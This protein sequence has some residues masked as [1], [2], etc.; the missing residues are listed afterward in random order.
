V[1]KYAIILIFT[2]VIALFTYNAT[3]SD[4]SR[5]TLTRN[6]ESYNNNQ[7]RNIANSAIQTLL[8]KIVDPDDNEFDVS[9]NNVQYF[10]GDGYYYWEELNGNYRYHIENQ[11]DTLLIVTSTGVVEGGEYSVDVV[12]DIGGDKWE[13]QF[14]LAVFAEKSIEMHASSRVIGHVGTNSTE[15]NAVK[16]T[17]VATIDSSLYIGP[18][19]DPD[20][21]VDI[22]AWRPTEQAI[23]GGIKNLNQPHNY[24]MPEFPDFPDLGDSQGDII[25]SGGPMNNLVLQPSDFHNQYFDEVKIQNNRTLTLNLGDQ[26]W[27]IR[28]GILN[29]HQGHLILN[30]TGA[31]TFYIEDEF[32][33]GGSST[34]NQNGQNS[35]S[36]IYYQGTD[37]I[38]IAGATKFKSNLFIENADLT[39]T[40]AGA[41]PL[42]TGHIISG[43]QNVTIAGAGSV[44]SGVIYAPTSHVIMGGSGSATTTI[45]SDTFESSGNARVYH[46][47]SIGD[48]FPDIDVG[49]L[50]YVIK[51]WN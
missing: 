37:G 24:P 1:G 47:G 11:D 3:M 33:I 22:P 18:G 39:I 42:E 17:G 14:P 48:D 32:K 44:Q 25:V 49:G 38:S 6:I 26:D 51:S 4:L 43:G 30:G 29:I 7:A 50:E 41:V 10:P 12:L 31:I 23:K 35:Q 45:V 15:T 36:M 9:S 21:V 2:L 5:S 13:P 28:V 34:L 8:Q 40:G 16:L 46:P 19:G 20:V 27:V